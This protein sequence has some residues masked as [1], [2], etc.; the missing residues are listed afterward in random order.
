MKVVMCGLIVLMLAGCNPSSGTP[1]YTE[2]QHE[3]M[4][5]AVETQPTNVPSERQTRESSKVPHEAALQRQGRCV[6]DGIGKT[7]CAPAGGGAQLDRLGQVVCGLGQCVVNSF[8]E[9]S[10]AGQPGGEAMLDAAGQAV[11]VGGCV[12][13]R[14]SYCRTQR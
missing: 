8:G 12:E 9:V 14:H 6:Q 5:K 4:G 2:A 11:C 13:A 10:C 1:P 7:I 3:T